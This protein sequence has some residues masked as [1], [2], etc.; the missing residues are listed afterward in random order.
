M[1]LPDILVLHTPKEQEV[2]RPVDWCSA[3]ECLSC[4]GSLS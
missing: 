3:K 2:N 1:S 4:G